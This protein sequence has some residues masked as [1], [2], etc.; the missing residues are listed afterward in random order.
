LFACAGVQT[1]R[2]SRVPG[3]VANEVTSLASTARA[4]SITP[5][6]WLRV[7]TPLNPAGGDFALLSV[8]SK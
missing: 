3:L 2:A 1:P 4:N 5:F 7:N 6:H 8:S